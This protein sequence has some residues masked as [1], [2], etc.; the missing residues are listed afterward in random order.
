MTEH[1]FTKYDARQYSCFE[2]RSPMV[3]SGSLSAPN[4]QL[5]TSK[6]S[7]GARTLKFANAK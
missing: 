2:F 3:R 7:F 4:Q 6:C 5:A 1:V